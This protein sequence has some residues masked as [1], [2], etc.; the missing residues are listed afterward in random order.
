VMSIE[1]DPLFAEVQVYWYTDTLLDALSSAPDLLESISRHL[2]RRMLEHCSH[3][4]IDAKPQALDAAEAQGCTSLSA[5]G[6]G[7]PRPV[8]C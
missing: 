3:I 6:G 5:V 4:S 7:R 1:G 8:N 2:S